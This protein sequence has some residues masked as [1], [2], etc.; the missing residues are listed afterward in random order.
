VATTSDR[1]AINPHAD[2]NIAATGTN[3]DTF[4]FAPHFGQDTISGFAAAGSSHDLLEFTASTFG[5]NLTAANQSA[6]LA[7]LLSHTSQNASGSAVIADLD[8][9]TL[10]LRGITKATLAL[11]ASAADLKFV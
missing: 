11:T 2:E 7:A 6:D 5:A 3:S 9:D 4:A 8:G 10:T 1:F